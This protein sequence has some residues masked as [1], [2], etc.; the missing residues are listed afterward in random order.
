[1]LRQIPVV[2]MLLLL[3]S[4][5]AAV[6]AEMVD[7]TQYASWAKYRPGT[8]ITISRQT[9][10]SGRTGMGEF[11]Q[12][13][14]ELTPEKAVVE[15][16][17]WVG[18]GENRHEQTQRTELPA[19]I[20]KGQGRAGLPSDF[21]GTTTDKDAAPVEIDGRSFQCTVVEF[22]GESKGAKLSG[23]I[24]ECDRIPGDMAKCEVKMDAPQK[25]ES[26]TTLKV[27]TI[28]AK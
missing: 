13:L 17:M 1:M 11:Q 3:L 19:K 4:V 8:T 18:T 14:V 22:S 21:V 23:T 27:K 16:V 28:E 12:R 24:W 9:T 2:L 10:M 6:R 20:E 25:P 5:D 7:S 26:V 15:T